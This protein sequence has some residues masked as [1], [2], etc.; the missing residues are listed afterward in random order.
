MPDT[1]CA[2]YEYPTFLATW[3]L[4]YGNSYED[5]PRRVPDITLQR[6][7][8]KVEPKVGLDEGLRETLAWF[9]SQMG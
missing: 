3:T 9:K 6:E 4:C 8:L 5:I 2:V 1:F 7:L